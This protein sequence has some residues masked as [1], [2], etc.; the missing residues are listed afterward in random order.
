[1]SGLEKA[2]H[3][4]CA[5][6]QAVGHSLLASEALFRFQASLC[7]ICGG[8]TGTVIVFRVPLFFPVSITSLVLILVFNSSSTELIVAFDCF[9]K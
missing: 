9:V 5:M 1:M 8:Q 3:G 4:G 2:P 7:G 6:A